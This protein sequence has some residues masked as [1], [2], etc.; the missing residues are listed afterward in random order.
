MSEQNVEAID[1]DV[2]VPNTDEGITATS[3]V[4]LEDQTLLL[5]ADLMEGGKEDEDTIKSLGKLAGLLSIE[6]N[7]PVKGKSSGHPHLLHTLIDMD[8]FETIVGYMDMRQTAAV[9][10]HATLCTSA[11]LKA[12]EDTGTEY[13]TKFFESRVNKGTYDDLI[14]AFSVAASIFPVVPSIAADLFLSDGFVQSLEPLMHRKRKSKKVEQAALEMLNA[15]CM[16]SACRK[17]IQKYCTEWLEEI[18]VAHQKNPHG[19]ASMNDHIIMEDGSLAA[20]KHAEN[21]VNLAAIILAKLQACHSF[22]V[23]SV[24]SFHLPL[25]PWDVL[26]DSSNEGSTI[27]PSERHRR[28]NSTCNYQH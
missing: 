15:A 6:N 27:C 24:L 21:V 8:G 11:Y 22:C 13:L 20:Q 23:P 4:S 16:N 28:K 19:D 17:A 2:S 18:I 5:I 26:T 7:D 25:S 14:L 3:D 1:T 12:A 10:G 9:R